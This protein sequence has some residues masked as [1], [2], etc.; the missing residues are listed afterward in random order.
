[1]EWFSKYFEWPF[2]PPFVTS[3]FL[4]LVL[5]FI[6]FLVFEFLE[7]EIDRVGKRVRRA[8]ELAI[9]FQRLRLFERKF[10]IP[11]S[12]ISRLN[13]SNSRRER[14]ERVAFICP[15]QDNYFFS[16]IR[17]P[18]CPF[19][20]LLDWSFSQ[21]LS[22]DFLAVFRFLIRFRLNMFYIWLI[23]LFK[24][25]GF[26]FPFWILASFCFYLICFFFFLILLAKLKRVPKA[27]FR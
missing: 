2:Y 14:E 12:L 3:V 10:I 20:S 27:R 23:S 1:M 18:E 9:G 25:L 11:K 13:I 6:T 21:I 22:G 15:N 26:H 4:S 8:R 16:V 7:R 24:L 17:I 19:S 5:K